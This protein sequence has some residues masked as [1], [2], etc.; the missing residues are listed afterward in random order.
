MRRAVHHV[1]AVGVGSGA[2]A[3]ASSRIVV[4][5]WTA[6]RVVAAVCAML[7][8]T[9][10]H[11]MDP[12]SAPSGDPAH[13]AI[14]AELIDAARRQNP[15]I[16]A[17]EARYQAMARRPVQEGTLP[18]PSIGVRYHNEETDRITLGESEFSF[19]EFS[20]EQEIPFPGKLGLRATMATREA[21]REAAMRDATVLMVLAN[22]A[23]RYIDIAVADRSLE[24]LAASTDTLRLVAEQSQVSYEVGSVAQQDYLRATLE[25]DALQERVV[26]LR[27]RRVSAEAALNAL[28]NRAATEPIATIAWSDA[29]V[30]VPP[31]AQLAA[32]VAERSP[33]VRAA[34]ETILRSDAAVAL[35]RREYFPDFAFMAAY[36]DKSRLLPEWE[37]GMRVK[38]PLYFWRRQRA[39]LAEAQYTRQDALQTARNVQV[40]LDSRLRELSTMADTARRLVD[41]YGGS[42]IPQASL[43]LESARA[44]YSVGKVDFLTM[45]NAFTALLEY[46][47]RYAEELGNLA[48]ARAEIGPIVGRAPLDW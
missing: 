10:A 7:A 46:R 2:D 20:A 14:L 12:P 26:M 39:G 34:Q 18:D 4:R 19:V 38:V 35:A 9:A 47:M 43:T 5:R 15:Q 42:L 48:R 21:A 1:F 44:S 45:L 36:T 40:T 30:G 11:A 29:I 22:V 41:L 28:L 6:R 27:Q 32:E 31:Y 16:R 17:A 13:S 25:R 8:A 24:I 3:E 37:V 33:E 23:S